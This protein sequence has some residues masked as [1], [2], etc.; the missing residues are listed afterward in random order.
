MAAGRIA[1]ATG[2]KLL[3]EVFPTRLERGAGLP[4]VERLAYVPELASVQLAGLKHLVLV[5]AKAPVTFFAYPGKKSNLVPDGCQLHELAAPDSDVIGS[6]GALVEALDAGHAEPELQQ[7]SRPERPNGPLT[8]ESACQAIG[9]LLPEGAIV[10]DGAATSGLTLLADTAGAPPHDLFT[11][12]GGA[13]GQGLPVSVGAAIACP[14]RPVLALE[15]E[16][17][18]LY[19]IQSLWTMAREGLDVTTVIFNNR[20]YA[21]LNMELQRVRAGSAGPKAQAQLSLSEPDMD[22]V[23]I[24]GGLGVPAVRATTAEEFGTA[25]ERAVAE[26]GPHLIEAIVPSVLSPRQ[27][28]AMP[29]ALRAIE[30]LPRPIGAALKRRLYP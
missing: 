6:L 15:G 2:A 7:P 24:S 1:A 5:D 20:S 17:S 12:T 10:S 29:Y 3:V 28:R 16:G 25:F 23:Q 19:T 9:A 22:F 21:I 14:D 4:V 30:S 13:I 11:V 18:A 27:L 8:A 26:P